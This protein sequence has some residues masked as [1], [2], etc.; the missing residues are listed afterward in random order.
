MKQNVNVPVNKTEYLKFKAIVHSFV[1][2]KGEKKLRL[3]DKLGEILD[4]SIRKFNTKN[5][6]VLK[7]IMEETK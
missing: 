7:Q 2:N 1:G 6:G 5:K 3:R 4:S